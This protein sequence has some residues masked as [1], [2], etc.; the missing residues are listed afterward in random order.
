MAL[1]NATTAENLG[2]LIDTW[3]WVVGGGTL[4]HAKQIPAGKVVAVRL[5]T[6]T[7]TAGSESS[8]ADRLLPEKTGGIDHVE[9]V[10]LLESQKFDGPIGPT[11]ASAHYKG[12]TRE[13][14]VQAGQEAVDAILTDA[15]LHVAPRPMDLIEDIPYEPTPSI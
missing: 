2:Y 3:D 5:G 10:K 8:T 9:L 6:V 1:I 12:Q 13:S 11:A 15:G 7:G 4:E 14:I